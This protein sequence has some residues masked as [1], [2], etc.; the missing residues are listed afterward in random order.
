MSQLYYREG[1]I[2]ENHLT[3]MLIKYYYE[4]GIYNAEKMIDLVEKEKITQKDFFDITR[5]N[6]RYMRKK[7]KGT[8]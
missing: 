1:I 8:W 5:L 3:L 7:I 2:M 4:S 6:Y